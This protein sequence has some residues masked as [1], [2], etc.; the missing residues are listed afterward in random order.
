MN[1]PRRQ[2]LHLAEGAA[3]LPAVQRFAFAQG[4]PTRP[5]T[6]IVFVSDRA[7]TGATTQQDR[8]AQAFTRTHA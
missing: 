3:A 1:L 8:V 2:F 7:G 6:L 5:V 4:Y